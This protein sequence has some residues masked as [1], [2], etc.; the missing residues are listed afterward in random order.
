MV[1]SDSEASSH[2]KSPGDV[3]V[4][5]QTQEREWAGPAWSGMEPTRSLVIFP[6]PLSEDVLA[7]FSYTLTP[8]HKVPRESP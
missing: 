2:A 7:I 6:S 3:L 4:E 5:L 8:G 1:G